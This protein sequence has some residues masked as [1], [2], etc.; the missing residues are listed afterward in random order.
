MHRKKKIILAIVGQSGA[1]KTELTKYLA[2]KYGIPF[3]VSYTT[4][5]MR[6]G[7]VDGVDHNFV[8][9]KDMPDFDKMIAFTIF[10]GN[11]YWATHSQIGDGITSYVIDERGLLKMIDNYN[12]YRYVKVYV[13]R[14]NNDVDEDRKSRDENR[15]ILHDKFYDLVIV[16]DYNGVEEF[17]EGSSKKIIEYLKEHKLW[18]EG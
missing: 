5:P 16:N 1:G 9:E 2:E 8:S 14:D 11:K 13:Y 7:E 10:G 4:R 15:I 3:V 17:L 12:K 6:E 18:A